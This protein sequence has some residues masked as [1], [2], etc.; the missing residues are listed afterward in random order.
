MAIR[1]YVKVENHKFTMTLPDYFNHNEV[2]VLV[3]PKKDE[4]L[5]IDPYFYERR[6]ELHKL[7]D[8]IKSGKEKMLS[9]EEFWEDM[10]NFD[11][12]LEEKYGN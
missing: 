3:L 8:D 7:R 4:N 9:H 12:E 10:D 2:E 1:E 5:E 11:K 6:E